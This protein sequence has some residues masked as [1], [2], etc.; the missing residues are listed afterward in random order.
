MTKAVTKPEA[1]SAWANTLAALGWMSLALSSITMVTVAG[2]MASSSIATVDIMALRSFFSFAVVVIV[3][4][5]TG[6]GLRR[7]RTE[8]LGLHS[9]RAFLHFTA[10]YAWLAALTMIPLAQLTALEFTAPLWVAVL[11]PLVLGERMTVFRLAAAGLG[12][13]GAL[14]AVAR[15]G[16]LDINLGTALAAFCAVGYGASMLATKKLISSESALAILFYMFLVQ[17]VMS[18]PFVLDGI[19][20]PDATGWAGVAIITFGGLV[21]HYSLARAF[22]CADAMIVAPMDFFRLP[23]VAMIGVALYG[24]PLDPMVLAGGA[25]VIGGNLLNLWGERRRKG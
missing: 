13:A 21:T 18:I 2:R 10:Q 23:I 24:E 9:V 20:S 7:M 8:R 16:A 12:F 25:L 15:P 6:H 11:A 17:S 5:A 1:K 14:V 4:V 22:A 3:A 19:G